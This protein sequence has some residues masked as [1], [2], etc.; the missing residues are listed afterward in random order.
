MTDDPGLISAV[1]IFLN[2]EKFLSEAIES[3]FAQTY[4][5]W[6][7]VLVDD[8]ST[9]GGGDIARRY[10]REHPQRVRYLEHPGHENRGMS[11]SRNLGVR[12]S[13]G[14]LI[15]FLD[16]DDVWLPRKLAAQYALACAH[17]DAGMICGAT[18]YWWSSYDARRKDVVIPLGVATDTLHPPPRLTLALYPLGRGAAPCP[19]DVLVRREVYERVGGF[20]EQF[21][22]GLQLYEDQAF[23]AKVYLTAPVYVS[24]ELWDRYRQHPSS[25][26]STVT[27]SG[28]Y[29]D[30]RRAF[31]HWFTQYLRDREIIHAD[32]WRGVGRAQW[33][34]RH[35]LLAG[36]ARLLRVAS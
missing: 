33:P 12:E 26:V 11:A 22:H 28:R 31:L 30:V 20:E 6:E 27:G 19:S 8:G 35:P 18:E 36:V 4:D 15:A 9:D 34:Y 13:R 5:R 1:V 29:H 24:S 2:A 17:P 14:D 21:R 10:A 3:V 32:V 23:F 7:L 16:A 25:C